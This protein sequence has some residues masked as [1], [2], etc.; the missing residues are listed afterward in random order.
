[1]ILVF[2]QCRDRPR[3]SEVYVEIQRFRSRFHKKN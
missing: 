2:T 3:L 1:M